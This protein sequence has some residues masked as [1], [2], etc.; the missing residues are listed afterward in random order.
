MKAF[1]F[2]RRVFPVKRLQSIFANSIRGAHELNCD[3]KHETAS[4]TF[5]KTYKVVDHSYDAIVIGAGGAGLRACYELG[6]NGYKVAVITKMF[7]TRSHTVAAQ[8]GVNAALGNMGQDDW[9]YH[10]YD[11][12]KGSDWL[13]DQ[14]A[15]SYMT[16]EAPRTILELENIGVPFS[17]T[18]EG[19]IYQ[20]S[21]G[22][23]SLEYGKGGKA[24][25][26]CAAADRTGHAILHGLYGRSLLYDVDYFLEYFVMD[27][28]FDQEGCRG[29]IAL[30]LED[31]LIHRFMA[32]NTI[33][34]TG[35]FGRIYFSCT[36]A[37]MCTGDGCSMI[38]RQGLPL[39]DCEFVQFHPTG[40]YPVG[41]LMTE[42]ARGEGG[43]LVNSEGERFM[44]RYAPNAKDLASRDVV[45]RAITLEIQ[46]GRGVGKDKDHMH[47]QLHHLDPKV[48]HERLPGISE[49]AK[50]FAGIDVTSENIPIIPTCHY[51]MGGIPTNYKGQVLSV[52]SNCNDCFV[53]GLY[54]CGECSAASVHG[55]NRLGA[56]SLLE[57]IIFGEACA[58]DIMKNDKPGAD[59]L[60]LSEDAGEKSIAN[61]D[62]IRSAKGDI[63]PADLQLEM[64]KT[65]QTYAGVFR[66]EKLLQEGICKVIECYQKFASLK[67]TDRNLIWNTELV[68]AME[69]QN[70]LDLAMVTISGAENRKES[71][72]AHARE[73]FKERLDEYDYSK[74]VLTQ[75]KRE[76]EFHWRKHTLAWIDKKGTVTF[77][78]RPVIDC[79]IYKDVEPIPPAVRSY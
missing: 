57:V 71:R 51:T 64:Q 34:A 19:K 41:I 50:I 43:Y 52:D 46:E 75:Q 59:F 2:G 31:G 13:G 42:G 15:I 54:A 45:S 49:S 35:G 72:G 1:S 48:L 23:Q 7:P 33:I 26:T 12:V 21:F 70:L 9:K 60:C 11:T 25:R 28:L 66:I 65:M 6:M 55:A 20:R 69:L 56:N 76:I 8:G 74:P 24:V 79:P 37:H 67:L 78:Y 58:R 17:R 61:L 32:K 53:P 39:Q 3:A 14:D 4:T 30:C 22:G 38:L 77:K 10:M 18:K 62:W 40:L 68:E 36:A 47:L 27:L 63:P 29:A 5:P 44:E 16:H 73:D